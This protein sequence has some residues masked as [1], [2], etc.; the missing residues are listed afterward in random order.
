MPG[1]VCVPLFTPVSSANHTEP[2]EYTGVPEMRVSSVST[3]PEQPGSSAA[4]AS[5]YLLDEIV[6]CVSVGAVSGFAIANTLMPEQ[7]EEH[8]PPLTFMLN[9]LTNSPAAGD[10]PS[11]ATVCRVWIGTPPTLIFLSPCAVTTDPASI[12]AL[13]AAKTS[14]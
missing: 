2:A 11:T 13:L 5:K 4:G 8:C 12:D 3:Q 9:E 1:T 6:L 10:F 14:S 7:P